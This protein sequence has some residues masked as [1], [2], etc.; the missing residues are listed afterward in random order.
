MC[1]A[2]QKESLHGEAEKE[3]GVS[4]VVAGKIRAMGIDV[5]LHSEIAGRSNVVSLPYQP[6]TNF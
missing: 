5:Q 6:G 2:D 1:N 3:E 4:R